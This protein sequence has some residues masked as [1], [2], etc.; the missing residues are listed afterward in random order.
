M[1]LSAKAPSV[2]EQLT[3]DTSKG[4]L[5]VVVVKRVTAVVSR[6]P[7]WAFVHQATAEEEEAGL[8]VDGGIGNG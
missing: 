2:V 3:A 4:R 8:K 1:S 5:W 6:M 7:R